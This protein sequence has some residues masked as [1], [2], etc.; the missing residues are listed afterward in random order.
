MHTLEK[1]LNNLPKWKVA[2]GLVFYNEITNLINWTKDFYGI[3]RSLISSVYDTHHGLRW[4][5][6]RELMPFEWSI[7]ESIKRVKEYNKLGVSFEVAFN[8]TL[9]KKNDLKDEYCNY[10]LKGVHN[11]MNSVIVASDL[12]KNYLRKN[13]PKFK[14][15]ASICFCEKS[16]KGYEKLFKKYDMVILH[17]DLNRDFDFIKKISPVNRERLC[18]LINEECVPNCLFRKEHYKKISQ[19][20][21]EQIYINKHINFFECLMR[22]R[23]KIIENNP[24]PL[25]EEE[26]KSLIS[27]GIKN[28]KIQGRQ[29]KFDYIANYIRDYIEKPAIRYLLRE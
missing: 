14:L 7:D 13:Y 17:P 6:G 24:M 15:A 12:L 10:F 28:F 20:A 4:T 23:K 29:L 21:L 8:N 5:G 11:K 3:N 26:V 2:G 22:K 27:L 18:V 25:K 1:K 19:K 9:L 16:I